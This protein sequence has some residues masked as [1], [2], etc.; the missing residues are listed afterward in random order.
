VTILGL[1]DAYEPAEVYLLTVA[2][3][4]PET[5]AAGF[6]L[7]ARYSGGP[8]RAEAAGDLRGVDSRVTV[9]THE[10]GQPYAH[11]T[12]LGTEV[13]T[14]EGSSWLVEW[15]APLE[16]EAVVFHV[17]AN[18]ANSD[19][20]PLLDLVYVAEASVGRK[21][22]RPSAPSIGWGGEGASPREASPPRSRR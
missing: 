19:N 8:L 4:A 17:A 14:S 3:E 11:H 2:L 20:S 9:T 5:G 12:P 15:T 16:G 21:P 10:T 13:A 18:S 7:S 6:Q 22:F 1:P